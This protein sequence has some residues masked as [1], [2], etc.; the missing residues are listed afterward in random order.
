[1]NSAHQRHAR[2]RVFGEMHNQ[3]N[4]TAAQGS[5]TAESPKAVMNVQGC[6]VSLAGWS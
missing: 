1:M 4:M 5:S 2:P 6:I 3:S